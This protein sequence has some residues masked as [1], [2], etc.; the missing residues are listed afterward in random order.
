MQEF[1][2]KII[3]NVIQF[4]VQ[5]DFRKKISVVVVGA[6][7]IVGT[8]SIVIWVSKTRYHTL[9]TD[10]N[11]EDTKRITILLEENKIP[12]QTTEDGKTIKIP[13][14]MV[15]KWR[16]K[17][18]TLGVRFTGTAGYEIFDNQSFGTTSFVQKIN[19]QRALEGELVKTIMYINGVKRA[20]V[21]LSIPESSPFIVDNKSPSASVVIDLHNG[22]SITEKEIKGISLLVSSSIDGMRPE[23]VVIVDGTGKIISENIGD[24]LTAYTSN[25]IA[26]E[27]KLN[28]KYEK[29]IEEILS[30]VVGNGKVIAKVKVN[31]D[32]TESVSTETSFDQES[33]AVVSEVQN[34][35]KMSGSRP[36]ARGIAGV[37]SNI[38]GEQP[39]TDSSSLRNDVDKS[40]T[41]KNYNVPSKIVKSRKPTAKVN[42][43]SA[44]VMIDGKYVPVLDK[45]G[46]QVVGDNGKKSTRYERWSK[47]DLNNFSAI[48]ASAIGIDAAR[49]DKLVIKNM[50]FVKHDLEEVSLMLKEKENKQL[51]H[52]IVKY[53][54][55][56]LIIS[57]FF[58]MV[59][60]PF[61]QWITDNTVEAVEDFLPKTLEELEKV[62]VEQKL[63]GLEDALPQIEDKMNPEKIEGNMLKEKIVSMVESNP[64]KAAQLIH[65]MIHA[66]EADKKIA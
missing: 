9:Y 51:M 20:R 1:F 49:G 18:A 59:V 36:T 28:R 26:L 35:Q 14:Q 61:I 24:E 47:D 64:T 2:E 57:L 8:V 12:Y 16:I 41:T 54:V 27:S 15:N 33:R 37:R 40:L 30:R 13:E 38:P 50:E 25:R 21:H 32:F 43:I 3:N 58:L 42:N 66:N 4:F 7:I 53:L 6:S 5:L 17:I 56:G 65:Q 52:N 63:P 45:Q 48:V 19:K 39:D 55:I 44:A 62:Q 60:R 46:N 22:V 11:R 29:Q 10:L 34:V 31:M 23:D